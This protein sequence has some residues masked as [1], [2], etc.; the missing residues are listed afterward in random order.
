[1]YHDPVD[2]RSGH[3]RVTFQIKPIHECRCDERLK[4]K[5]DSPGIC[6]PRIHWVDR[7]TG[8]PKLEIETRLLD[9]KFASLMCECV[10]YM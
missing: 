10:I 3:I 5:A 8:T 7:G 1:M 6:A 2:P 9:E 4:T